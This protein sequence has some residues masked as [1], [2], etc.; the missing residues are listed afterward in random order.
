MNATGAN[1]TRLLVRR[2]ASGTN[3]TW[4]LEAGYGVVDWHG[5]APGAPPP[6]PAPKPPPPPPGPRPPPAPAPP[7]SDACTFLNDTDYKAGFFHKDECA[8]AAEC[9][10]AC[11][12]KPGCGVAVFVEGGGECFLKKTTTEKVHSPGRV[13]CQP[14]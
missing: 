1:G 6:M 14:K 7:P 4:F 8:T 13:S 11:K 2:F 3:V 12:A 10:G 9:C 5:H